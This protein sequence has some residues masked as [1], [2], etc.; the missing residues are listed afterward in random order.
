[1]RIYR[2]NNAQIVIEIA[3][4]ID[5]QGFQVLEP[6]TGHYPTEIVVLDIKKERKI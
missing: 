5:V 2:G 3:P 6:E 1:M 4:S